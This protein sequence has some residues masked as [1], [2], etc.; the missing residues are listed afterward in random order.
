MSRHVRIPPTREVFYS[1]TTG[2]KIV[3]PSVIG[4]HVG[5]LIT[6]IWVGGCYTEVLVPWDFKELVELA[7]ALIPITSEFKALMTVSIFTQYAKKGQVYTEN[8]IVDGI[9]VPIQHSFEAVAGYIQE[10]NITDMVQRTNQFA[11]R[12]L[13]AGDYLGVDVES[14]ATRGDNLDAR[15][16]GI[17]M[18]YKVF[19]GK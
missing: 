9:A 18:R 6:P 2:S 12:G 10:V 17:R 7:V 15:V 19:K 4:A 5:F 14:N 11:D 16:L 8:N 1:P 13:E 3:S